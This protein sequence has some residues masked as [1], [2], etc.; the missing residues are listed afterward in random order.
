MKKKKLLL[1]A[2]TAALTV[3]ASLGALAACTS[4]NPTSS[5]DEGKKV[6]SLTWTIADFESWETGIQLIRTGKYF[7][8][9]SPNEDAKYVKSGKGSAH[10]QPL[11]GY[12]TGSIPRFFFPTASELF[13]FDN[14]DFSDAKEI[15]FE[16]FNAEETPVNVAVGLVPSIQTVDEYSMTE[17]EYVALAP[18][19][20]TTVK[21][22]VD[23]SVLAIAHDV[24]NIRGVYVSFENVN[25]RELEDAPSVYLDDVLLTRYQVAPVIRD[26]ITIE[27][28]TMLDFE[29]DWSQYV[30]GVRNT[31]NAPSV[32]VVTASE[33]TV[34]ATEETQVPLQAQSGDKV[35]EVTA[36]T[37]DN[38]NNYPGISLSGA[39]FTKSM[40]GK[41]QPSDY[42]SVTFSF[43]LYDNFDV[44][45]G[46]TTKESHR[47]GMFF[48]SGRKQVQ[49][50][51]YGEPYQ[52][53][54]FSLSMRDL[55]DTWQA[56]YSGNDEIFTAP[57]GFS[58]FWPDHTGAER[59]IYIDNMHFTVDELD[60]TAKP[61]ITVAPFERNVRVGSL[62][63]MP[64][65]TVTD[66]YDLELPVS[67]QVQYKNNG[68]WEDVTLNKG[69]IPVSK[70]GEYQIIVSTT[71]A[72][73]N[74][75]T[76][77]LPFRGVTDVA[78]NIWA[79]YDYADEVNAI[80]MRDGAN[81]TKEWLES[82]EFG[83]ET[84]NGVVKASFGSAD[85]YG[86]GYLGIRLAPALLD[87]AADAAWDYFVI[88][89]CIEADA[90]AV[91]FYSLNSKLS[92]SIKT[93]TWVS[94]KISKD[95]LNTAIRS[96]VNQ[97]NQ[98]LEDKV[99][100]NNFEKAYGPYATTSLIYTTTIKETSA[101]PTVTYYIDK[102]TWVKAENGSYPEG[103][104]YVPDIYEDEWADP[105]MGKKQDE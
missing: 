96:W 78:S 89:M 49:Y 101:N 68:V 21:Y 67:M 4:S 40:F 29:E 53:N 64:T 20:W 99:F 25:S 81:N 11:G 37:G 72:L 31:T 34:G 48:T 26:I 85:Q 51:F 41:M 17:Q 10:L 104:G 12:R 83:G 8:A 22:T 102:I 38:A 87:R 60:T 1:T 92:D 79:S 59:K 80:T 45:V 84:R 54:T 77:Y 69:K 2:I 52:W 15:T 9:I 90:N 7:G 30:I 71:N 43:D 24:T 61:T 27:G 14:S 88:D 62:I 50:I 42:G 66:K 16:F 95:M 3:S 98:P 74:T 70:A 86:A 13:D 93:G 18:Q 46:K 97:T 32:K 57:S 19:E 58:L 5:S 91:N 105:F 6:R 65:A 76:E 63:N 35:L 103:D 94:L 23:T 56:K 44:Q 55:Y 33:V 82:V 36:K 28:N 73:G 47:Y 75:T 39:L 100:Y